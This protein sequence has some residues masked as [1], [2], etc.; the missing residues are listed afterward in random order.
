M[1]NIPP[2]SVSLT[3]V[4]GLDSTS[5]TF[6]FTQVI[7]FSLDFIRNTISLVDRQQGAFTFDY[8]LMATGAITISGGIT[9]VTLSA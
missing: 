9:S 7:S 8:S 2:A 5:R 4:L 6:V 3:G 1:A